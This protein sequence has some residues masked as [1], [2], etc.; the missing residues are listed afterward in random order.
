MAFEKTDLY[1]KNIYRTFLFILAAAIPFYIFIPQLAIGMLLITWLARILLTKRLQFTKIGLE[2]AFLAFVLAEFISLPF[3]TNFMQSVVFLKRMLLL[4]I[5][6]FLATGIEDESDVKKVVYIFIIA[7]GVYSFSGIISYILNP[8]VRVRHIHNSMTAGGITMLSAL[9]AFAVGFK[10]KNN[11]WKVPVLFIGILNSVCLILTAT[12]GSWVG[13]F[14][15]LIVIFYYVNRKLL[16]F[17]PVILLI[18]YLLL[19]ANF[20][21]RVENIFNPK[22]SSNALRLHWWKKGVEIFKDHPIVG[23]GDV[24]AAD[25]Y[26]KYK[27]PDE[28]VIGHFHNNFVHIAVILGSLGLLAFSFMT[29]SIFVNLSRQFKKLKS[30]WCI[31]ALAMFT[32]FH[33]NGLFEWNFGDQEVITI[34]WFSIGLAMF[35]NISEPRTRLK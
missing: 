7:T 12:R 28:E 17:I 32:A 18:F 29:I 5:V 24:G 22:Y 10:M 33:I 1:L 34:I 25:V 8:A 15:G 20:K 31:A 35:Q 14:A 13:F 30:G 9:A 2:Y 11:K 23:I 26:R 16:L 4:P 27:D 19:P 21:Y 3:S 6:Y